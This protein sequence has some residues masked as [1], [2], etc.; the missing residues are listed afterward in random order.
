M[1]TN[2]LPASPLPHDPRGYGQLVKNKLFHN[3]VM[4]LIK[5]NR[6]TKK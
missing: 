3:M 1:V 6:I 5:L 4:L 2:I